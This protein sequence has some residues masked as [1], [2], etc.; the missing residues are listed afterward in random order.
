MNHLQDMLKDI[1][2]EVSMTSE[3][4]GKKVLDPRVMTAMEQVSRHHFLPSEIQYRAYD[5]RPVSIGLGQTISQPFI[6]ALMSDLMNPKQQD[7][8]L[9]IG[10]GSGYQAAVLSRIVQTVYSIEIIATLSEKAQNRL[11]KLGYNNIEVRTGDGYFGWPEHAPYDG[12]IVTA[13]TPYIPHPLIE[14]LKPDGRLVIPVGYPDGI[15]H[16]M[17]IEKR[18]DGKIESCSVLGVRFVPMTGDHDT[19]PADKVLLKTGKTL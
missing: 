16:L 1:E 14:Q 18:A 9:E 13:A 4:T 2:M 7:I 10:T 19:D 12:I 17:V 15:Q 3:N 11:R 8:I 6:V 5:N